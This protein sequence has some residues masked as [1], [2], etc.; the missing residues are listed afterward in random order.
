MKMLS[1]S[2]LRTLFISLLALSPTLVSAAANPGKIHISRVKSLV[3][4]SGAKT[5]GRRNS[6]IPQ[7][8]CVGGDAKGL[9]DVDVMRCR[10]MGSDYGDEGDASWECTAELPKWFKLGS[11]DVLC[12][13]YSSPEDAYIL[14][15]SCGVEYRLLLTDAGHQK[16]PGRNGWGSKL[17]PDGGSLDWTDIA[18]YLLFIGVLGYIIYAACTSITP[19]EGRRPGGNR[20][21]FGGGGGG[22]GGGGPGD[23]P[24]P[25]EYKPSSPPTQQGAWRPGFWSGMAA[26]AAARHLMGTGN[27]ERTR[28]PFENIQHRGGDPGDGGLFGG[29]GSGSRRSTYD[30]GDPG[31]SSRVSST[32]YGQTR[33]R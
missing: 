32:S 29:F 12:E 23:P 20:P 25:Y 2:S 17:K 21:G 28:P 9:Y 19:A 33:R 26:G 10:N 7:L 18:F 15:G 6:P 31:S 8:K 22:F 24:P 5:T 1:H 30:D 11:T 4:R 3:L 16:Y 13:G 14:K 27:R